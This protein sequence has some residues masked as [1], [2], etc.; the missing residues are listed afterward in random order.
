M[1]RYFIELSYKGTR[2]SGFQVQKNAITIQSEVEKA[3]TVRFRQS[4]NLTGASRTDAGV[5]ALQNYFHFDTADDLVPSD[6][7]GAVNKEA[8]QVLYS[9]NSILPD[10]I[11][12]KR[13]FKVGDKVHCRF[14]AISRSYKY[15]IYR[16]KNP[17]YKDTAYFYPYQVDVDALQQAASI[18]KDTE[19]FTSFCKR[20]AQVRNFSC[21]IYK[22][23]WQKTDNGI[24]YEVIANRFL[25]GM[26]RGIVGTMLRVGT[27]KISLNEFEQVIKNNNSAGVDFS[28]P[29][30]GLYLIEIRYN[31]I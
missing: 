8:K 2:Y 1:P 19:N 29:S 31:S 11:A 7:N 27:G 22:S 25:R 17:F 6:E 5:H 4:F 15:H 14:D 30:R 24:I 20:N 9:L 23:E 21:I 13:I 12:I 18:I 16:E 26:V 28:V 10:D 3:L